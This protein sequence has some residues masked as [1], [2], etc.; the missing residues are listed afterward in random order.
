MLGHF[1][2]K[3]VI[4]GR[5]QLHVFNAFNV[6]KAQQSNQ[7][8]NYVLNSGVKFAYLGFAKTFQKL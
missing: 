6:S 7:D 1:H 3:R 5:L 4:S 2:E 8:P